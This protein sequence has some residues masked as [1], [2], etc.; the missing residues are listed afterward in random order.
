MSQ[1][2]P[3]IV[4]SLNDAVRDTCRAIGFNEI[5]LELWPKK[6][7]KEAA[8]YLN[9]CLNPERPHKLDGEEILYIAKRGRETGIHLIAGFIC[10][11]AGYGP[12]TPVDPDDRKAELQREFMSGV[13]GSS[14]WRRSCSRGVDAA[15][16]P[17]LRYP[18][19]G[20]AVGSPTGARSSAR[21]GSGAV[22]RG[23]G[24]GRCERDSQ[25]WFWRSSRAGPARL[26]RSP[27]A[28]A[29]RW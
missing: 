19:S 4:D 22:A 1:Q 7:P 11:E 26:T 15:A 25:R 20:A 6:G 14:A 29:F 21:N 28:L 12:P 13:S 8:R 17:Q 3:L 23:R 24:E 16:R 18:R 2:F 10:M 27:S 5:A 9:D